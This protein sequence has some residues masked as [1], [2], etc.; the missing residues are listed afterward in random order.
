MIWPFESMVNDA[1]SVQLSDVSESVATVW[2]FGCD[3]EAYYRIRAR[4][5][6]HG[7]GGSCVRELRVLIDIGDRDDHGQCPGAV[8]VERLHDY[9]VSISCLVVRRAVEG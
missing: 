1:A 7:S 8:P 6:L 2:V 3:W 4:V 5:L 9:V